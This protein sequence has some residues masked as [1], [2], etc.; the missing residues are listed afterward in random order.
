MPELNGP[1]TPTALASAMSASVS[2]RSIRFRMVE[3]SAAH[4]IKPRGAC[5]EAIDGD[6]QRP[7]SLRRSSSRGGQNMW[8]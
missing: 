2:A 3:R 8:D 7:R 4:V 5:Q 6:Y 1:A